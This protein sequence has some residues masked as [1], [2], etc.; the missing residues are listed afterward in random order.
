[1][2]D[3]LHRLILAD[4]ARR[5]RLFV[6]RCDGAAAATAGYMALDR[7]A[8]L[9]GGVTLPRF[10]RRG[11]YHALVGARLRPAAERGLALA[12]SLAIAD[13]SAPILAQMGFAVVAPAI[14]FVND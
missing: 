4:P 7:S 6:A 1:P 13:T 14:V 11:L 12:T 5:H 2:L 8:Y 3:A 9:V 10:R